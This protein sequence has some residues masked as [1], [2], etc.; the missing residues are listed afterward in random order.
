MHNRNC[1]FWLKIEL[2][3]NARLKCSEL[4]NLCIVLCNDLSVGYSS[5]KPI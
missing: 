2:P 5:V 4:M 1:P 3:G